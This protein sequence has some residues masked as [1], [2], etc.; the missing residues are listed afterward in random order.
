MF[1]LFQTI[2]K[3]IEYMINHSNVDCR[4]FSKENAKKNTI[5]SNNFFN[6]NNFLYHVVI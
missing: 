5:N 3:S 1:M 2:T 6:P 4:K